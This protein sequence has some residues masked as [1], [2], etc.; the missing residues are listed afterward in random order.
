MVTPGAPEDDPRVLDLIT[1]K[2]FAGMWQ[3]AAAITSAHVYWME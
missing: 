1:G 2:K 3:I